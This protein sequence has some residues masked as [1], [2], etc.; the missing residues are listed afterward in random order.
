MVNKHG[1]G[2]LLHPLVA[3]DRRVE[4]LLRCGL[5]ATLY[6]T[7]T[8]RRR[9]DAARRA[10]AAIATASARVHTKQ[11]APRAGTREASTDLNPGG[12]LDGRYTECA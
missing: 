5:G 1:S 8:S 3:A 7:L 11:E 6:P 4:L 12:G 2:H 10:C 9:A